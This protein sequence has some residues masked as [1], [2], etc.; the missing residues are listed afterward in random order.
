[1]LRGVDVLLAACDRVAVVTANLL[2]A[3]MLVAN[4]VTML[5]REVAG[6]GIIH[7]FPLTMVGFAWVVFIGFYVVYRRRADVVMAVLVAR[8]RGVVSRLLATAAALGGLFL[9]AVILRE[10]PRVME[11]SSGIVEIVELPKRWVI[12]PLFVSCLLLAVDGLVTLV[13]I[14]TTGGMD[15]PQGER[16]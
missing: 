6:K 16:P 14:W 15:R 3:A 11:L 9:L 2:L 1:M 8:C 13:R 4:L 12:A 5:V 7:V 10:A